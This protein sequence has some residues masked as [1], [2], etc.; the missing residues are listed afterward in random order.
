MCAYGWRTNDDYWL[1]FPGIGTFRLRPEEN[2]VAVIDGS[3]L[4]SPLILDAFYTAVLPLAYQLAGLEALH[5][6]AVLTPVGVVALCAVSETGKSTLAYGLSQRGH[7]LWTD[8]VLVFEV[9]SSPEVVCRP[10]P[11]TPHLRPETRAHF[12]VGHEEATALRTGA[13]FPRRSRLAALVLIERD[14]GDGRRSAWKRLSLA[15]ALPAVLPH[16]FRFSLKDPERLR[17]TMQAYLDLVARVPVIR[18]RFLPDFDRLPQVLDELE[19]A[20]RDALAHGA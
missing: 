16:A 8:D 11:F 13:D 10:V 20:V 7:L 5:A 9:D 6:S 4:N 3:D 1:R 18:L 15:E 19:N 14:E 17:R 12:Q 2:E